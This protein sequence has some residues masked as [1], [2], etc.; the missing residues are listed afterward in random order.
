MATHFEAQ[1]GVA[2]QGFGQSVE[3]GKRRLVELGAGGVEEESGS[4]EDKGL[5]HLASSSSVG[6]FG[7][8]EGCVSK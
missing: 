8:W 7:M 2:L 5:E 6:T 3:L 4:A 1:F